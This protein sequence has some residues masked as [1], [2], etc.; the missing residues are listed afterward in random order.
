MMIEELRK[1]WPEK[2][3]DIS[4][5]LESKTRG[6][7]SIKAGGFERMTELREDKEHVAACKQ[8]H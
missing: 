2:F 8:N 1:S 7:A 5:K 3:I 6:F 4:C